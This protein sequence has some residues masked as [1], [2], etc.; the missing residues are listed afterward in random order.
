[1]ASGMGTIFLYSCWGH[2][3]GMSMI[4]VECFMLG[5]TLKCLCL[6]TLSYLCKAGMILLLSYASRFKV[7]NF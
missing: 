1:M 5:L 4:V 7:V 6:F 2:L 3:Q